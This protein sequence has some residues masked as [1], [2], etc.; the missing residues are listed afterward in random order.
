M[1][2]YSQQIYP[3]YSN[4]PFITDSQK[5]Y[6]Y[7][8]KYE[9]GA[10]AIR[11]ISEGLTKYQWHAIITNNGIVIEQMSNISGTRVL[12][13]PVRDIVDFDFTFD[14]NANPNFTYTLIDGSSF[15]YFYDT[16]TQQYETL[17]LPLWKNPRISLDDKRNFNQLKSD[18]ICAGIVNN[19]LV[20]RLQRERFTIQ[21]TLFKND[22]LLDKQLR[23]IGMG[24]EYRFQF[25]FEVDEDL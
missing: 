3:L 20:Y 14:Q 24:I 13:L 21:R 23:K 7:K 6:P 15:I 8:E 9:M 18:I 22:W 12:F 19:K 25:Q 4:K 1:F 5:V 11:D 17:Q 10:V 2:P 16:V